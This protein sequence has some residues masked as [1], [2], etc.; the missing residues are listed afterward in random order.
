MQVV[1]AIDP[2]PRGGS[3]VLCD[4]RGVRSHERNCQMRHL[5]QA[6]KGAGVMKH[7]VV[8]EDV[9]SYGMLVGREVFDT[10]KNIGEIRGAC[11]QHGVPFDLLSR[12]QVKTALCR[13]ARA[14]DAN[15]R[16]ALMD[17]YGGSREAAVGRKASPGPLYGLVADEWAALAL[18]LVWLSRQGLGPLVRRDGPEG[19]AEMRSA[20]EAS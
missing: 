20:E 15:V 4:E 9:V 17:L 12:V 19:L 1:L 16:A 10:V 5:K 18:G 6:I 13:S 7:Q 11:R 2:D 14:K 3:W 8:V